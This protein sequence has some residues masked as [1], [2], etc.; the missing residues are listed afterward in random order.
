MSNR[1]TLSGCLPSCSRCNREK[2]DRKFEASEAWLL[3]LSTIRLNADIAR[4]IA[5]AFDRDEPKAQLLVKVEVAA[6]RGELTQDEI[7]AVF[8]NLPTLIR[9]SAAKLP[10]TRLRVTPGWDVIEE[11]DGPLVVVSHNGRYGVTSASGDQNWICANCGQKGP[12]SG[13]RCLSCGRM[14]DPND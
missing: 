1:K 13:S 8:T 6:T 14:S 4:W 2:S 10:A 3:R 11:D 12:W 5:E 9:R 7:Q